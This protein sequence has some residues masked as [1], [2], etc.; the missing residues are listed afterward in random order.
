MS[1]SSSVSNVAFAAIISTLTLLPVVSGGRV[2][3]S[4]ELPSFN[5]FYHGPLPST[6]TEKADPP[7][8]IEGHDE[9]NEDPRMKLLTLLRKLAK[10]EKW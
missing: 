5:P 7:T 1:G 2:N 4:Q 9:G 6:P 10:S 8:H 3:T